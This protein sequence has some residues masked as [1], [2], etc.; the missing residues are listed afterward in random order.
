MIYE[1]DTGRIL[2]YSGSV[3]QPP[4]NTAWGILG[5]SQQSTTTT[6][7]TTSQVDIA[8]SSIT[9]TVAANR[10]IRMTANIEP[11][12]ASQAWANFYPWQDS[13]QLNQM[14]VPRSDAYVATV[15]MRITLTNTITTSVAATSVF[16]WRFSSPT[17]VS[18]SVFGSA[19]EY[20]QY[21]VED[22]GPV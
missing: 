5:V 14:P 21:T 8:G 9:A 19:G 3:W 22:I 17:A 2:V 16:K 13:T 20:G 1:T 18:C 4:W 10:R 6:N 11:Y 15:G 7:A 12:Y